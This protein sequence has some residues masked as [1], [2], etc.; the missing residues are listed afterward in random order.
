MLQRA[1]RRG[2]LASGAVARFG[3]GRREVRGRQA[4]VKMTGPGARLGLLGAGLGTAVGWGRGVVLT[5]CH[6]AQ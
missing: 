2:G 4:T 5:R 3:Q 6:D 1:N